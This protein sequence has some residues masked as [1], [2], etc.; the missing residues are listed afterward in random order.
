MVD[1]HLIQRTIVCF[2]MGGMLMYT[3]IIHIQSRN[4]VNHLKEVSQ[5]TNSL[6]TQLRCDEL[7][8]KLNNMIKCR[9]VSV[10]I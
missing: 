4:N 9:I 1:L 2:N 3:A 8:K 6:N 7:E 10:K 5:T